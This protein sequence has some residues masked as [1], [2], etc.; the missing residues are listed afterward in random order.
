MNMWDAVYVFHPVTGELERYMQA[1]LLFNILTDMN[2]SP[3]EKSQQVVYGC[4]G[5]TDTNMLF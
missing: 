4:G 2:Y 1:D 5:I 3:S